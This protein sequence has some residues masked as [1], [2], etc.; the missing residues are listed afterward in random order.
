MKNITEKPWLTPDET[1]EALE[2]MTDSAECMRNVADFASLRKELRSKLI[3]QAK[4]L[5]DFVNFHHRCIIDE[6]LM[7]GLEAM[8]ESKKS[9]VI[10]EMME[11]LENHVSNYNRR[12]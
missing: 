12:K 11:A 10:K 6:A 9:S 4:V 3:V 5:D 2:V 7:I 1:V 8:A